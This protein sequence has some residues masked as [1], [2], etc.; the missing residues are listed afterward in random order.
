MKMRVY[1]EDTDAGGVVYHANY[2]RFCERARS[3]LFFE[4]EINIF[5][6]TRGHFLLTKANCE[7]KSPARLGDMLDI[8]TKL[9]LI[10]HA[11]LQILQEIYRGDTLCFKAHFTLAY[12]IDEK[13][14][15]MP[16]PLVEAMAGLFE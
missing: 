11:S 16:R 5:D 7:F 8:K 1:Y 6:P 13:V 3:E 14:C 4:K 2:L 12:L 9:E 10:K 15:P